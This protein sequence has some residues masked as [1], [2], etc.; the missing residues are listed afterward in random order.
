VA[1]ELGLKVDFQIV[2]LGGRKIE[3]NIGFSIWS[4]PDG[5]L[6]D[7]GLTEDG[8][9][10]YKEPLVIF[11]LSGLTGMSYVIKWV[12]RSIPLKR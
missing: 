1:R 11:S 4:G 9:G 3:S 10:S 5:G 2:L 7:G 12:V 8:D 6:T